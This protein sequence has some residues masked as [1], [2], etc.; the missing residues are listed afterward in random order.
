M[1]RT[2]R[3]DGE[4]VGRSIVGAER[5]RLPLWLTASEADLLAALSAT[6]PVVSGGSGDAENAA[7]E[8]LFERL[9]AFRQQFRSF[10]TTVRRGA[11]VRNDRIVR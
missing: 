10:A 1:F 6:S 11:I 2:G 3:I 9:G 7:E 5:V 8:D 4:H